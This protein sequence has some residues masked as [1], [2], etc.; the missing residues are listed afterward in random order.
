[1]ADL[2]AGMHLFRIG[3]RDKAMYQKVVLE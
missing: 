2:P 1:L 3:S